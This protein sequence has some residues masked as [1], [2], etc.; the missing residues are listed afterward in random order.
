MRIPLTEGPRNAWAVLLEK[1]SMLC[2]SGLTLRYAD[3]L[4]DGG[5]Q[6][7]RN[8]CIASK[9]LDA[10]GLAPLHYRSLHNSRSV[11]TIA[12]LQVTGAAP[13]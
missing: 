11:P 1:W 3:D 5:V 6:D 10:D 4:L 9:A 2:T 8:G 13:S 12:T 7:Q